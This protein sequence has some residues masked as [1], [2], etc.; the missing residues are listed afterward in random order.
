MEIAYLLVGIVTLLI[1]FMVCSWIVN[2]AVEKGHER[3]HLFAICFWLGVAGMIYVASLPNLKVE[4]Q[5]KEIDNS[6][7]ETTRILKAIQTKLEDL[8]KKVEYNSNAES[9]V[10]PRGAKKVEISEEED[11]YVGAEMSISASIVEDTAYEPTECKIP[12]DMM[13][14]CPNCG[15]DNMLHITTCA[16][17]TGKHR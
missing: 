9:S 7:Y 16:C 14:K 4:K 10:H 11:G 17:G 8:Q 3:G 2:V 5:L 6:I 12:T 1:Q 15:Q 13:W